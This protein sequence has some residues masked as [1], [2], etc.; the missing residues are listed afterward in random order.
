MALSIDL[1][2]KSPSLLYKSEL[3]IE[4]I[5]WVQNGHH[6]QFGQAGGWTEAA[7]E[8]SDLMD[9]DISNGHR[10]GRGLLQTYSELSVPIG[11]QHPFVEVKR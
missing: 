11:G 6:G 4:Q 9:G 3:E 7:E 8:W 2:S 5:L 1:L 10:K